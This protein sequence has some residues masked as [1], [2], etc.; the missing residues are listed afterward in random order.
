MYF[1]PAIELYVIDNEATINDSTGAIEHNYNVFGMIIA[2]IEG[3]LCSNLKISCEKSPDDHDNNYTQTIMENISSHNIFNFGYS[4]EVNA[5]EIYNAFFGC[6]S[7]V[8]HQNK[9]NYVFYKRNN[10][11]LQFYISIEHFS[12]WNTFTMAYFDPTSSGHNSRTCTL[13]IHLLS[14][15]HL[16]KMLSVYTESDI[17]KYNPYD[18]RKKYSIYNMKEMIKRA[19]SYIAAIILTMPLPVQQ[20]S[21]TAIDNSQNLLYSILIEHIKDKSNDCHLQIIKRVI[22]S[23]T[24]TD[25]DKIDII[26]CL[27]N[28][29]D[30]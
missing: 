20:V 8:V 7:K 10:S 28:Q 5:D 9:N 27:L 13:D 6:K 25:S 18:T 22:T 17:Y 1:N 23:G 4:G 15:F 30:R 26:K 12:R 16:G 11:V 2:K 21:T 19:Q 14:K 3:Y 29:L 24:I